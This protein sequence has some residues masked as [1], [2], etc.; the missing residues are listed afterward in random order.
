MLEIRNII[1]LNPD[2]DISADDICRQFSYS[3][4]YMRAAYK[5][6]FGISFHQDCINSRLSMAKYL[7][8]TTNMTIAAIADKCGYCDQKY[9]IRQFLTGTGITPNQYRTKLT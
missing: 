2:E 4:G 1:Y 3:P 6:C 9:F 5:N 7:L 8:A